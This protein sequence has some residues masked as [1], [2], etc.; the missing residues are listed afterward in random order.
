MRFTI[1]GRVLVFTLLVSAATGL[2][3][4]MVPA[5]QA[6]RPDLTDALKD[7][8]RGAG[9]GRGSRRVRSALV[10]AEMS[11]S[12]VLLIGAS[13]MMLSFVRLQ[14]VDPGFDYRNT[15]TMQVALNDA[16]YDS[17][18]TRWQAL[19]RI[20]S[21]V[22]A[23]P[24]VRGAALV[25]LTPLTGA[26]ATTGF[27]VDGEPLTSGGAHPA[28]VRSISPSY[29]DVMGIR[30]AR[31]RGFTR[32]ELSDSAPVVVINQTLAA[33]HWPNADPIGK[34]IRWGITTDDPLF[35]IVGIV[36]DVKQRKLGAAVQPQMYVPYTQYAYRTMTMVVATDRTPGALASA[37]R[38]KVREVAPAVPLYGLQTMREIY[39][40][41]VWQERLL[42]TLFTSFAVIALVLAA[43]GV[44]SV[45]AY[46]VTQRRHEIGVRM[47]LG[48]RRLDVFRLVVHGG[49]RLAFLGIAIGAVGAFAA[50][51]LLARLLFGVSPT[52]PLVFGGMALML[53]MTALVASYVPAR[54]AA[55]LDPVNALKND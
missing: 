35:T 1:D 13:L 30:L 8:A 55:S 28:E 27:F 34:R 12:L 39:R 54:R 36:A 46:S 16:R 32:A 42:G 26:Q 18:F 37:V 53:L 44:Y 38:T 33:L 29:F 51:R 23:L 40:R 3:F 4:G 10:V 7:G 9:A 15:L 11:L 43:A 47:A 31:G 25:S 14:S 52:D 45:I 49:A 24:G 6:S 20:A 48:A 22:S 21:E 41:S 19:D 17:L 5:L 50:T 2:V